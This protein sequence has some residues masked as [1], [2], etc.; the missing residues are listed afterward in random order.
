M[1]SLKNQV[2]VVTG[3]EQRYRQSHCAYT[4]GSRGR[5]LSCLQEQR[6]AWRNGKRSSKIWGTG[7]TYSVD[8]TK[9]EDI[10]PSGE[11]LEREGAGLNILVLCGGAI[12]HGPHEKAPLADLDLMY[13]SNV[14]WPLRLDPNDAAALAQGEGPDCF[15][16]IPPP[17]CAHPRTLVNSPPP[18]T[19]F[20]RLPTACAMKSTSTAF[21]VLSIFPGRTATP[22]MKK[23][24]VPYL[25][26]GAVD[27]A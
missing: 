13:R 2:A 16:Q 21:A 12:A 7:Y 22:R 15:R 9:D 3:G 17:G 14:R 6:S 5:T 8:R 27:A 25:Q 23:L 20:G 24:F 1:D 10:R 19:L 18:S 11:K 26:T 4:R